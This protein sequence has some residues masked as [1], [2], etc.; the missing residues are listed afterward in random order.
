MRLGGAISSLKAWGGVISQVLDSHFPDKPY[1]AILALW[2]S[3]WPSD[4]GL[5]VEQV[6]V[7]KCWKEDSN[8]TAGGLGGTGCPQPQEAPQVGLCAD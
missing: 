7:G 3:A 2:S 6:S 4:K 1:W 5:T 8:L